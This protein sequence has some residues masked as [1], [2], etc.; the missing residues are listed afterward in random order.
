[1]SWVRVESSVR[2]NRKFLQAGPAAS[3]LWLCANAYCQETLTDGFVPFEAVR[4]LGVDNPK[5]LIARLVKARLWD[6]CEGGWEIHDYLQHNKSAED[7]R[8]VRAIR[9]ANGARGGEASGEARRKQVASTDAKQPSNPST[10]TAEATAT[11]E[12]R[13]PS[14][15]PAVLEY[16]TVGTGPKVWGL[17]QAQADSWR[18][19]YPNIDV[20][21]ECR[22]ARTWL[23]ANPAKRKTASGMPRFLVQW[24]NRCVDR[25]SRPTL[26]QAPVDA[27]KP[28]DP[29]RNLRFGRDS[30]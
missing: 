22:K 23:E 20:L 25:G 1:M 3:W 5:P 9:Q 19:S 16:E 24:L 15:Q 18:E 7:V 30:H 4:F 17:T 29:Y 8:S 14:S 11:E 6:E 21:G 10:S 27:P 28:V 12:S 2:T 26:V 13:E